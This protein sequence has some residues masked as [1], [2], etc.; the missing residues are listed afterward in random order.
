MISPE[1]G[2][3]TPHAAPTAEWGLHLLDGQVALGN[4]V[5]IAN[6]EAGAFAKQAAK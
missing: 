4:L 6:A 5:G 3:Q 1:G 2:A